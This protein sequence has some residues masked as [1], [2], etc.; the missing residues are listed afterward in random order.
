MRSVN[1]M[2]EDDNI[3]TKPITQT[4]K[5]IQA[6]NAKY[7]SV[8]DVQS[9]FHAIRYKPGTAEPTAIYVDLPKAL[10][11]EGKNLTGS[12]TYKRLVM[13]CK[14]S[15]AALHR[16][17]ECVLHDLPGVKIYCDDLL[18][19]SATKTEGLERL[20]QVLERFREYGVK[21]APSKCELLKTECN[22]LGFRITG[23]HITPEH[24]K[25]KRI[26]DL[27]FPTSVK[28]LR[29]TVGVFN[30][31]KSFIKGYNKHANYLTALTKKNA[32]WNT[33]RSPEALR[34]FEY[35]KGELLKCPT[36]MNPTSGQRF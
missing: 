34:A 30:Y 25:L 20:R 1:E 19:F 17:M 36:L 33:P 6:V 4:I 21:L 12:Y 7:F 31:F 26:K 8:L 16:V 2:L 5:E 24:D 15:S 28:E 27:T 10:S 3:T 32:K 35:L 18:I 13:G 22:Y 14:T 11:S 29:S 9:A 23:K